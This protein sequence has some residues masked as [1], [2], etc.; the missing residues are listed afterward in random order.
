VLHFIIELGV[1]NMSPVS[2]MRSTTS[3]LGPLG[4]LT[5]HSL[6]GVSEVT[7]SPSAKGVPLLLY[8]MTSSA[9]LAGGTAT[10]RSLPVSRQQP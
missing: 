3:R 1:S 4:M 5:K 9:S 7:F 8:L 10:L 6:S 2:T